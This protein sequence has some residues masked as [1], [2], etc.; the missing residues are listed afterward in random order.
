[1]KHY[2]LHSTHRLL[3]FGVALA[4]IVFGLWA[5]RQALRPENAR[6]E[7]AQ[8]MTGIHDHEMV[9]MR[10]VGGAGV[11]VK[12][13]PSSVVIRRRELQTPDPLGEIPTRVGFDLFEDAHFQGETVRTEH[14]GPDR[15]VISGSLANGEGEFILAR[16]GDAVAGHLETPGRG[17]FRIRSSADGGLVAEEW[18]PASL[19][20]CPGGHERDA[21]PW[22]PVSLAQNRA[23]TELHQLIRETAASN[24]VEG[25]VFN[26]SGQQGGSADGL[27]FTEIDV[28]VVYTVNARNLAGGTNEIEALIDLA[29]A[30]ANSVFINSEVGIRLRLVR[31][32]EVAYTEIDNDTDL[33]NIQLGNGA[34]ASVPGWR[35]ASGADLVSLFSTGSGG[36]AFLYNG[37]GNAADFGYSVVGIAGAESTFIHEVGH[38]LSLRHDRQNDNTNNPL[39][40]YSHGWR[41]TP[42]GSP[43]LRT[44]MAYAPGSEVPYFSNPDVTY[45]GTATGV[46]IGETLES[47]NA[48]T[49]RNTKAAI[50]AFRSA[51]GNVPPVVSFDSPTYE[52]SFFALEDVNLAATASDSD[53][54]VS[55][56]RFYRLKSDDDYGFSNT[57]SVSLGADAT[58]P[59][60]LTEM[61][62]PAGFWTYAVAAFDGNGGYGFDTISIVV[63]PHYRRTTYALPAGKLRA[64][65]EGMNASGLFVGYGHNGNSNATDVQAAYW[66]NGSVTSLSPLGG[67]TGAKAR[68]VDDSGVIYGE[69]ISAGGVRRAVKWDNGTPTDLSA[70][71]GGYTAE[72]VVGVDASGR[73]HFEGDADG[74]AF[75][76]YRRF[77][78]PGSTNPGGNVNWERV[79]TTGDY[80][81][82]IDYDFGPGAWRALRWDNGITLLDPLPTTYV[83][84]WGQDINRSGAA[85]GLSS[86]S[87]GWSSST[88]RATFWAAGSTVPVDLG[89]FGDTGSVAYGIND[90]DHAVGTANHPLDG[91]LAFLWK[92]TGSLIDLNQVILPESGLFRTAKVINNQGQIAGT[93]FVGSSQIVF[94]LDPLPGVEHDYWLGKYFTPSEIES[95]TLTGDNVS[96]SNDGISN[97]YKRAFGLNPRQ[98]VDNNPTDL[99]SLPRLTIDAQGYA[100]FTIRRLRV[101]GDLTYQ[102][103]ATTDLTA[104]NWSDNLFEVIQVTP[105]SDDLEE[106]VLRSLQPLAPNDPFFIH[107]DVTR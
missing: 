106:V 79:G 33:D 73:L 27:T 22:H 95:G 7:G 70:T 84:S 81:T 46:A 51:N 93:G 3:G 91:G 28:M 104:N 35:N 1:M 49:L 62:A 87:S 76:D 39:Y 99:D 74:N 94:F 15:W 12:E 18:D 34:F 78:D 105:L 67:D 68:A 92:G 44:V 102:P 80:S 10:L 25:S 8:H 58:A 23:R 29:L 45:M 17:H 88:A 60:A 14:L 19:P 90:F 26:G 75:T 2:V 41:F 32:E 57:D 31:V 82:G 77:N 107:L 4:V 20:P 86:P 13:E 48:Q 37:G 36:L 69:S 89:T 56:V 64:E 55:E 63:S 24:P 83:S 85:V 53:G 97:L 11:H 21:S 47:N 30:R 103:Q 16:N 54:S 5:G 72:S 66:E 42:S 71:I 6:E 101:P 96:A 50:A 52:E 43:E 59:Y 98:S 40:S 61:S 65:V 100:V 38:N 9:E